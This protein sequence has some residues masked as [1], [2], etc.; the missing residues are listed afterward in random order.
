M[1]SYGSLGAR[2]GG[3]VRGVV[4]QQAFDQQVPPPWQPGQPCEPR[5]K[6]INKAGG[7]NV[8]RKEA[9]LFCKTSSGV[10]LCWEL[11]E[12]QGPKGPRTP[13]R[14]GCLSICVNSIAA[15]H[16]AAAGLVYQQPRES[17]MDK[18]PPEPR[19]ELMKRILPLAVEVGGFGLMVRVGG[20]LGARRRA[21]PLALTH[22]LSLSLTLTLTHSLPLSLSLT[23]PHSLTLAL[24]TRRRRGSPCLHNIHSSPS[25]STHS[26]SLSLTHSR[27]LSLSLS[28]SLTLSHSLPHS[29]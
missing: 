18:Q 20:S 11:E 13:P 21:S 9:W 28:L 6:L 5:C 25:T 29:L 1:P 10:R 24:S 26:R 19:R 3:G 14:R 8:I 27:S 15:G 22:S 16:R 7:L 12:P 2:V 4:D 17:P 23:H